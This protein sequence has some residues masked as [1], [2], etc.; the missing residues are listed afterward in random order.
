MSYRL[1]SLAFATTVVI[2]ITAG[3]SASRGAEA[4]KGVKV[5]KVPTLTFLL[6]IF[7]YCIN[8]LFNRRCFLV[9]K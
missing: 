4:I 7:Y 1:V 2:V 9:V 8:D 3:A 6:V 5:G